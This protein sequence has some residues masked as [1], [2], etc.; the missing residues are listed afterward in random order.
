[1]GA[2]Y[3][4]VI[5]LPR[6][7]RF[8]PENIIVVGLIP[9]PTEPKLS[10][11]TFLKPLV[12]ELLEFLVGVPLD[13]GGSSHLTRC[14]LLCVACDVPAAR[15][16]CRFLSHSANS[17]CSRCWK[18][19]PGPV[20]H[21]NYSGFDRSSWTPCSMDEHRKH[22]KKIMTTKHC[23]EG[24][25][26]T[27]KYGCRYSELLR[28]LY[29]DPVCMCIIDPMHCLFL[30]IG[31]HIL[32]HIWVERGILRTDHEMFQHIESTMEKLNY[33]SLLGRIPKSILCSFG[34]FT[35]DQM[36]NWCNI[37]SL[38]TLRGV[39]VD[40]HWECWKHFV[41]ASRILCQ[42]RIRCRISRCFAASIL[43]QGCEFTVVIVLHLIC[44][45]HAILKNA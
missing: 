37:F 7:L 15:K 19:F 41:L 2:I 33:P 40:E 6:Q 45:W 30:G 39:L 44:I 24:K 11:N 27:A 3:L 43:P 13:Y 32:K 28:L 36:K 12:D 9:G 16:V 21:K 4:S 38:F 34:S 1:M 20:G 22:V 25:E 14:A 8:K 5:N 29:F 42:Q 31:K 17:G 23:R 18:Q 10:I 35:A 26:L